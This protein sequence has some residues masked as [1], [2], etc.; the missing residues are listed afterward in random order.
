MHLDLEKGLWVVPGEYA[1]NGKPHTV[2]LS[3]PALELLSQTPQAG[4]L[5]FSGDDTTLFQDYSKAK[6]RLDRI[7]G[8]S[9]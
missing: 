9:G 4:D 7:S 8:V 6:V 5:V 3:H 2:H 1:K